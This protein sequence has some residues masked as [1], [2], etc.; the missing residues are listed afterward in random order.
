MT[1]AASALENK[2]NTVVWVA[3]NQELAGI[4][5]LADTPKPEA[6]Q[7]VQ[8]LEEF[9]EKSRSAFWLTKLRN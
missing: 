5:A 6:A 7:V 8:K 9:G 3:I 4:V 2:G 1:S